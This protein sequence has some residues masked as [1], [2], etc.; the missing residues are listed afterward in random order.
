MQNAD[1]PQSSVRMSPTTYR[2]LHTLEWMWHTLL[3]LVMIASGVAAYRWPSAGIV[4]VV[5]LIILAATLISNTRHSHTDTTLWRTLP[6]PA[7]RSLRRAPV[8]KPQTDT[9]HYNGVLDASRSHVEMDI[10]ARMGHLEVGAGA[11]IPPRS[12]SQLL[13]KVWPLTQ[14]VVGAPVIEAQGASGAFG[15]CELGLSGIYRVYV[16]LVPPPSPDQ[17]CPYTVSVSRTV[18]P[19]DLEDG[20]EIGWLELTQRAGSRPG[21]RRR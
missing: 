10:W 7:H 11:L 5:A 12:K 13:L 19:E 16:G 15:A 21:R 18:W 9:V 3:V 6:Q 17:Q 20:A 1:W 14:G 8:P 4:G 2:R